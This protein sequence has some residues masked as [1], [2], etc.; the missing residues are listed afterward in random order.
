MGHGTWW[1]SLTITFLHE[2]LIIFRYVSP[3]HRSCRF[4]CFCK[5]YAVD[6]C[7]NAVGLERKWEAYGETVWNY[8]V[9]N[10]SILYRLKAVN[11][12]RN[13]WETIPIYLIWYSY[14]INTMVIIY[15]QQRLNLIFLF[16]ICFVFC[17]LWISRK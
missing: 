6:T 1:N 13:I 9:V 3:I 17:S 8:T 2:H 11:T 10:D 5:A 4:C 12:K 7:N 16:C 15:F 14:T